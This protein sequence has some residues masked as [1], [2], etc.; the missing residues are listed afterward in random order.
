MSS[1]SF[2]SELRI[3]LKRFSHTDYDKLCAVFPKETAQLVILARTFEFRSFPRASAWA[4]LR[5]AGVPKSERVVQEL[6]DAD[7]LVPDEN[8]VRISI[9]AK[10][11]RELCSMLKAVSP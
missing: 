10:K 11:L 2:L 5:S 8:G 9:P 4:K 3:L 6:I 1:D 7:A